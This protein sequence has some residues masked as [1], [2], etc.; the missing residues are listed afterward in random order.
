MR[1]QLIIRP[2]GAKSGRPNG[3]IKLQR[4]KSAVMAFLALSVGIGVLIAV[5]ILGSILAVAIILIVLLAIAAWFGTR[6]WRGKK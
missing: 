5:I 1:Y 2:P 3:P 4:L 6:L